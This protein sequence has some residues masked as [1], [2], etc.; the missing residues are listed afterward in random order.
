MPGILQPL[1]CSC[2]PQ[3]QHL[4]HIQHCLL[5]WKLQRKLRT[6][7]RPLKRLLG[8]RHPRQPQLSLKWRLSRKNRSQKSL[9]A[10]QQ[11]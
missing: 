8:L 1:K 9:Q 6:I 5:P 10:M 11:D 3:D 4:N 7:Q 2:T